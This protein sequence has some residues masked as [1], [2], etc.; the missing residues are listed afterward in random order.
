MQKALMQE[1]SH[2]LYS[3]VTGSHELYS[4]VTGSHELYSLI[5]STAEPNNLWQN[6]AVSQVLLRLSDH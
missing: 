2:E 1:L 6:F 4:L 3:L 5:P